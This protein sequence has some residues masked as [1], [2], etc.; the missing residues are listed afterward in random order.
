M[1]QRN[2]WLDYKKDYFCPSQPAFVSKQIQLFFF[3]L[4]PS[5]CFGISKQ[6][7]AEEMG[8]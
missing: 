8:L 3:P 2:L 6:G 4:S 7:M 5:L 1:V